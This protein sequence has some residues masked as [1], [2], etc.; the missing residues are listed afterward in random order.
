[1]AARSVGNR[2]RFTLALIIEWQEAIHAIDEL[3][4]KLD[5]RSTPTPVPTA[6][7]LVTDHFGGR[8]RFDRLGLPLPA[9]L[10][11][12][13]AAGRTLSARLAVLDPEGKYNAPAVNRVKGKGGMKKWKGKDGTT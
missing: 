10:V 1:M 9:T 2:E 8:E 11:D 7:A 6:E 13:I 5:R 3:I 12:W 4:E